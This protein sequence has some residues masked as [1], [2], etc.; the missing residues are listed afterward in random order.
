VKYTVL[1]LRHGLWIP[2]REYYQ[3]ALR[4]CTP[5]A[6]PTGTTK[7][8]FK[9]PG[10]G[11]NFTELYLIVHECFGGTKDYPRLDILKYRSNQ[12]WKPTSDFKPTMFDEDTV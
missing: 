12:R 7:S 10:C 8:R 11:E 4:Q 6:G 3:F 5:V 2:V 1:Q 9:C